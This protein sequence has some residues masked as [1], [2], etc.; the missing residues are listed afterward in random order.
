VS[1]RR[2]DGLFDGEDASMGES[3]SLLGMMVWWSSWSTGL[4]DSLCCCCCVTVCAPDADVGDEDVDEDDG[5]CRIDLG[6]GSDNV[7]GDDEAAVLYP[8]RV[9]PFVTAVDV[10]AG[11]VAADIVPVFGVVIGVPEP[12]WLWLWEKAATAA[13]LAEATGRA[14]AA[15]IPGA[16]IVA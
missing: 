16:V 10:V 9:C 4:T 14:Y 5:R 13:S 6:G 7:S 3:S 8:D 1:A 12:I 11:E 15:D 2:G